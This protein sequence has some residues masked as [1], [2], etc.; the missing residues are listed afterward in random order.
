MPKETLTANHIKSNRGS[1]FEA[2]EVGEVRSIL[3]YVRISHAR[4]MPKEP[5]YLV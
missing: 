3:W 2:V 4:Q 5:L 1:Y